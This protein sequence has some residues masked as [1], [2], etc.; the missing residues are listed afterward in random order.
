MQTETSVTCTA[1][2]FLSFKFQVEERKRRRISAILK[3]MEC[4][5][6]ICPSEVRQLQGCTILSP[7]TRGKSDKGTVTILIV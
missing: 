6:A 4:K 1:Y 3:R 7:K 5:Q 2:P